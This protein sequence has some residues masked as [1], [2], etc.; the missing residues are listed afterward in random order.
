MTDPIELVLAE[1]AA[2]RTADE[3]V[4]G[5]AVPGVPLVSR[6]TV[7]QVRDLMAG[8]GVA[9]L[10]GW[11]IPPACRRCGIPVDPRYGDPLPDLCALC[12]REVN[13]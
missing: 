8:D 13:T 12:Q 7:A 6:P 4:I 9:V 2:G 1:W 5:H 3:V 11:D 10:V